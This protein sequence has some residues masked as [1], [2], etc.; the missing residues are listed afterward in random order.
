MTTS[1]KTHKFLEIMDTCASLQKSYSVFPCT[2]LVSGL[3]MGKFCKW[4]KLPMF[5]IQIWCAQSLLLEKAVLCTVVQ[6]L[7]LA[8]SSYVP[9]LQS[10]PQIGAVGRVCNTSGVDNTF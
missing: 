3:L 1:H 9:L 4:W 7:D 10:K 6:S 8:F 5:P 2:S